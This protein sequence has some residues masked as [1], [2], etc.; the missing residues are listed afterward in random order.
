VTALQSDERHVVVG[1]DALAEALA[2]NGQSE[3]SNRDVTQWHHRVVQ[4]ILGLGATVIGL[5]HVTKNPETR[6]RGSRGAGAKLAV[7]SGVSYSVRA[8]TPLTRDSVGVLELKV[9]KDRHGSIGPHGKAAFRLRIE[10][11][12]GSGT[13]FLRHEW[14]LLDTPTRFLPTYLME[15]L[16]RALEGSADEISSSDWLALVPGKRQ[17]QLEA[18]K[19]LIEYGYVVAQR[20]GKH[21]LHRSVKPYRENTVPGSDMVPTQFPEPCS[22]VVPGSPPLMKGTVRTASEESVFDLAMT[23]RGE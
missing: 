23:G 22:D 4:R 9:A 11:E 18:K 10:P 20:V 2:M 7:V 14:E 1:I 8:T 5:D 21:L 3:D 6:T 17:A 12:Q 19:A 16:S 13:T 15:Q